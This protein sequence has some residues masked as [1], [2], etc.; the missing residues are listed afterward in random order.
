MKFIYLDHLL[1]DDVDDGGQVVLELL[2][3]RSELGFLFERVLEFQNLK[4]G[5][6]G[7]GVVE[8]GRGETFAHVDRAEFVLGE[9]GG[10]GGV[11]R[12]RE[13]VRVLH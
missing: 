12:G 10:E 13:G 3:E 4:V 6:E 1:F 7:F 11:G 5:F 9:P 2:E 8:E